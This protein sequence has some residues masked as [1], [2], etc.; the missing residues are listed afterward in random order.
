MNK[1]RIMIIIVIIL[2]VIV[3]LGGC[4]NKKLSN[5]KIK[6]MDYTIV[7]ESDIPEELQKIIAMKKEKKMQL[8][9]VDEGYMYICVG[10]GKQETGGYSI[11]VKDLYLTKNAI[12]IDSTLVGPNE[13]D[14]VLKAASYPYLVIKIES[15]DK[16][17]RYN[18]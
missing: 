14:L 6:D 12:C 1:K 13:N 18:L 3:I 15:I 5:N 8:T 17:V 4:E 7:E 9:Y 11:K 10:Y 16:S 2:V